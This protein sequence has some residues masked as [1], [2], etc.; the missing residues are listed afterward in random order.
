MEQ[1]NQRPRLQKLFIKNFRAIGS[2]QVEIELD[3]I[4]VLVGPNNAGKSSILRAYE[5]VMSD[6]SKKC[7]LT[8]D[9]FPHGKISPENLPEIILETVV[10]ENLPAEKWIDKTTGENVVRERWKWDTVGKPKR[11]GWNVNEQNWDIQVPWG[12]ANVANSRRPLP[13]KVDAFSDPEEQTVAITKLLTTIITNRVKSLTVNNGEE[14]AE[15][16]EFGK[17]MEQVKDIQNKIFDESKDEIEKAEDGISDIIKEIFPDYKIKFDVRPEDDLDKSIN[18]FKAGSK[19]LMGP[20]TGYQSTIDRQ[21]SG[22]RRTLLWAALRYLSETA[23]NNERPNVLLL[24]EPEL[25]LHPNA[26]RE[27][28][29]V[30]YELPLKSNWQVMVTTHSPAFVDISKD[31]TT[32]VRVEREL[33]GQIKGTTLFR[34]ERAKLDENDRKLLKLLNICDPYVAEFFF[35]GRSIIV[36]G[37]TEYTAFKYIIANYPEEF[38]DVHIIRARGKATIVSLVKILNHFGTSY[39]V[40]HDSDYPKLVS[41]NKNPAWTTNQKIL[42]A[43]SEHV[44]PTKVRLIASLKNFEFAFLTNEVSSEKPYNAL[45]EI[46]ENLEL[47]IKV[48]SL[49]SAL[50]DHTAPIPLGCLEWGN[51]EDLHSYYSELASPSSI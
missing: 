26:V 12:A 10:Y 50:I 27:S 13:H 42:D 28:C 48:K 41:G 34:P 51:I 23:S 39:S 11:S 37:D 29:R 35:G 17:L 24:D 4:V 19:L 44:D 22:A 5:I 15:L 3:D 16:T 8:L 9:D 49:L 21:G 7:E 36:E 2:Q 46:S 30:L 43:V 32:I 45:L 14:Q 31:N 47:A 25:C 40:L 18:L 6:G 38:K 20:T 1:E 33:S